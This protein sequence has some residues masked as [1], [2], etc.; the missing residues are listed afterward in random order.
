MAIKKIENLKNITTMKKLLFVLFTALLGTGVCLAD[1]AKGVKKIVTTVFVTDIDCPHCSKKVLN[2]IPYEKGVKD[3]KVDVPTKT[4]TVT[5]DASKNN[6]ESLKKAL[7][8]IKVKVS[9]TKRQ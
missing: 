9:E 7:N 3:V 1:N 4:V 5:Y 6:D 2:T 8:D